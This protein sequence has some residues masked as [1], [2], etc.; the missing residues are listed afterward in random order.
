DAACRV[1]TDVQTPGAAL[2]RLRRPSGRLS[3]RDLLHPPQKRCIASLG[4][5]LPFL[6][7]VMPAKAYKVI[8]PGW[9][10]Y[11]LEAPD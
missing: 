11:R 1:A 5:A 4:R 6:L 3:K 7:A 8:I 9:Q 10:N 2:R